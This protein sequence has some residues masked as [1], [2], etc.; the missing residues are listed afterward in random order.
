MLSVLFFGGPV[1]LYAILVALP[2]GRPALKGAL[3]VAAGLVVLWLMLLLLTLS[4]DLETVGFFGLLFLS[5]AWFIASTL[6][7]LRLRLP[8]S[9]PGWVWPL[10]AVAT[11]AVMG[12]VI[13]RLLGV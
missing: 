7:V 6:Q 5:A 2:K 13:P 8:D 10:C 4:A 12:L 11:F 9:A 1:L 3:I